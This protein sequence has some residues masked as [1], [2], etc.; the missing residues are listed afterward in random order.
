VTACSRHPCA[1][2]RTLRGRRR[3]PPVVVREVTKRTSRCVDELPVTVPDVENR[4]VV[5][6]KGPLTDA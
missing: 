4:P 1:E 2:R 3:S 5:P 6:Q